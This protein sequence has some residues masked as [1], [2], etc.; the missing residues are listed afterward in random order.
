MDKKKRKPHTIHDNKN[1]FKPLIAVNKLFNFGKILIFYSFIFIFIFFILNVNF[2]D[3][4]FFLL[5]LQKKKEIEDKNKK[6]A[7]ITEKCMKQFNNDELRQKL[8][9]YKHET[10]GQSL[11]HIAARYCRSKLSSFLIQEIKIGICHLD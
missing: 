9:D 5:L 6:D 2:G 10:N 4:K 11:L 8:R 7:E 1:L 3:K